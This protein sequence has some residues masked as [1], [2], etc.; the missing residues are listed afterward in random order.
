MA[1]LVGEVPG[2][3]R[4]LKTKRVTGYW[5]PIVRWA[6]LI[7][8]GVG[9]VGPLSIAGWMFFTDAP[10]LEEQMKG[11]TAED[12]WR[13]MASFHLFFGSAGGVLLAH[14]I[15]SER[16]DRHLDYSPSSL[17]AAIQVHQKRIDRERKRERALEHE[18]WRLE[19]EAWKS[20][21][22]TRLYELIMNQQARGVLDDPDDLAG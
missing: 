21:E 2:W 22:T 3:I 7:T 9:C 14:M 4:A 12:L 18:Q 6:C 17:R 16:K 20:R 11:I 15:R 13:T 5:L 19:R 8:V 10:S 1:S